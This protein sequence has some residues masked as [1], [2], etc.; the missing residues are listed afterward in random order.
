M[1]NIIQ[2]LFKN[3]ALRIALTMSVLC[4]FLLVASASYR[5]DSVIADP[6]TAWHALE[7]AIVD[8]KNSKPKNAAE[9]S[10][11]GLGKNLA[12]LESAKLLDS[13][14]IYHTD[15]SVTDKQIADAELVL[16]E[17]SALEN[18][19][20]ASSKSRLP[21]NVSVQSYDTAGNQ[22]SLVNK[23]DSTRAELFDALSAD[24][25]SVPTEQQI[26]DLLTR[27][28]SAN[29]PQGVIPATVL[30]KVEQSTGISPEEVQAL[31]DQE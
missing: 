14:P 21:S 29:T 20:Q 2:F 19:H 4:Y 12:L 23:G 27:G 28:A 18:Q 8:A 24:P 17:M 13:V 22:L 10:K 16:Q 25:E 6:V 30:D 26:N 7:L 31:L 3:T 1:Q 15:G 5:Y 11:Y 9:E